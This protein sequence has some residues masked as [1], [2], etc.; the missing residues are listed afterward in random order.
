MLGIFLSIARSYLCD[1]PEKK[2]SETE[3]ADS[4]DWEDEESSDEDA[5]NANAE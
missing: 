4:D 2:G 1:A 5:S 3:Q